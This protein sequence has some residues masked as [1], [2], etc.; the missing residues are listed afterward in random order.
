M[1]LKN[2]FPLLFH[3]LLYLFD[4]FVAQRSFLNRY[5]PTLAAHASCTPRLQ[6]TINSTATMGLLPLGLALIVL[7]IDSAI[8]L[9]LI[10]SMVGYL[11]R[12][13][14]NIYPFLTGDSTNPLVYVNAKPAGLLLNEGHTSNGAAGTALVLIC[15]GGFITLWHQRRRQRLVKTQNSKQRSDSSNEESECLKTLSTVPDLHNLHHPLLP[16]YNRSSGLHLRR[17]EPDERSVHR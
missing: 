15:F 2:R 8:E 4:V 6:I 1:V 10:S 5:L 11:H 13:G 17:H 9:A 3:I 16:S 14:A 7:M 12:S